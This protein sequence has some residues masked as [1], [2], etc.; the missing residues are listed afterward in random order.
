[1]GR[2]LIVT[3]AILFLLCLPGLSSAQ[4]PV[5]SILPFYG[6]ENQRPEG[7]LFCNGGEVSR[8]SHPELYS[9]L[10]TANSDLRV[11]ADRAYLPD[12]RG[13]FLRGLDLGRGVDVDRPLG[14]SQSSQAA[15]PQHD[16]EL[17]QRIGR[18]NGWSG[19]WGSV[20]SQ[21]AV[22]GPG[23]RAMV[24]QSSE[25]RRDTHPRNIAVNFIIRAVP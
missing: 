20:G 22:N 16:H 13:E 7:W 8:H 10:I 24:V 9:H 21:R 23:D 6:N 25:I 1:M 3:L 17:S 18:S 14:G 2:K 15:L 4:L 12:L 19:G 5:G 11:D